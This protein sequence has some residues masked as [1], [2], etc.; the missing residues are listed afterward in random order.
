MK[1]S[2]VVKCHLIYEVRIQHNPPN[3]LLDIFDLVRPDTCVLNEGVEV[4]LDS[5]QEEHKQQ[6][7]KHQD[8][9][10]EFLLK[11]DRV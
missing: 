7:Y 2:I 3:T 4:Y 6:E 9:R 1:C 10:H 8:I 5:C 11:Y